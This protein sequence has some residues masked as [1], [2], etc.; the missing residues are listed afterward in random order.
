MDADLCLSAAVTRDSPY[1][2]MIEEGAGIHRPGTALQRSDGKRVG[3]E[4]GPSCSGRERRR[5]RRS[6]RVGTLETPIQGGPTCSL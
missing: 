3:A 6:T 5:L 2:N 1:F 4:G